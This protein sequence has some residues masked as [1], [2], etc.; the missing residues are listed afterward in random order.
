MTRRWCPRILDEYAYCRCCELHDIAYGKYGLRLVGDM[1]SRAEADRRFRECMVLYGAWR[2]WAWACW[3]AL[4]L[5]GWAWWQAP[6]QP[7]EGGRM[8]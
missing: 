4:R 2:P 7:R 1:V 3:L 5:F 8:Q 6:K